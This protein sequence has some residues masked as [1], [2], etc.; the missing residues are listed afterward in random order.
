MA[1]SVDAP[2]LKDILDQIKKGE[3]QL[4]EFQRG[5]VWD[6]PHTWNELRRQRGA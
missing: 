3:I 2:F 6:D 1:F 4:P 5:W